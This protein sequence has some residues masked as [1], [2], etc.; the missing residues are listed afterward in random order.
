MPNR[1]LLQVNQTALKISDEELIRAYLTTQHS[2][3]FNQ[4]YTKY[5]VKIYGK[6]LF[7]LKNESAA[8]D[9][10][11]D[12]FIK[13]YSKLSQ[14]K[15]KSKFSTWVYSITYN[16]CIDL[17]RKQRKG[18]YIVTTEIE[19][20]YDL[21][22]K[23]IDNTLLE[24]KVEMLAH[25]LESISS[26]DKTVLL[27]KYKNAMPIKEIAGVLNKSESAIKMKLKRAKS[28]AK[29]VYKEKFTPFSMV[30]DDI[31]DYQWSNETLLQ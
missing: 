19:Q 30:S 2:T 27:M 24:E 14:F 6:C 5:S 16:Y 31:Y 26:S 8:Q 15:E 9:A 13:V 23:N 29:K 11:Q 3:Y 25:V 17:I 28:R 12:I 10:T 4:L 21:A 18:R 1:K 20:I 7:L 22:E